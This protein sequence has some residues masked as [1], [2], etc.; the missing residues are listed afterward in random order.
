MKKIQEAIDGVKCFLLDLDGT[1]YL[2][3]EL[4]GD[5]K[6]TLSAIRDSGRRIV[7]LTNNSSKSRDVY[8]KRLTDIGIFD[9]RDTVFTSGMSTVSYLNKNHNGH[10]VYLMGTN[11]LK[12]EF[13]KG[14]VNLV[15]DEPSVVVISYDTELDYS[16]ITKVTQFL[17]KGAKYITTHGDMLCPAK[18][19]Y[20]PD[21]GTYINMF[22]SATGR[23]PE[24][25]C[26]KPDKVMGE[27]IMDLLGLKPSVIMMCGD[28]LST[29][30][31]FGVN[32][33]F[34]S[35]LVLSGETDEKTYAK[36]SI[37]ASFILDDLNCIKEY[38]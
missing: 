35:L 3:G 20:L 8:I 14:G 25:N 29:D 32:N 1:V 13:R 38:L 4:I 22:E 15:E 23:R 19:N 30:I 17:S 7:Y 10:P 9:E 33:G 5:M 26:G 36:S 6:S 37:K 34:W 12:E 16:K 21:V 24:V 18:I 2:E 11:A 28:R 31:A 27:S